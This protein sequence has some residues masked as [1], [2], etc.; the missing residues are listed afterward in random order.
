VG[1]WAGNAG[2]VYAAGGG[3]A[4]PPEHRRGPGRRGKTDDANV[5][6]ELPREISIADASGKILGLQELKKRY[7]EMMV[8]ACGGNI[9]Q[10]A[11][12]LGERHQLLYGLLNKRHR[13][14]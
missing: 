3:Y 8:S 6:R 12:L 13:R 1:Q 11:R 2:A 7:A 14:K 10:A 9:K 5:L 4:P